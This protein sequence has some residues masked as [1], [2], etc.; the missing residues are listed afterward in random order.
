MRRPA[1]GNSVLP[2]RPDF[3]ALTIVSARRSSERRLAFM[4]LVAT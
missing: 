1:K 4:N 2:P 3:D